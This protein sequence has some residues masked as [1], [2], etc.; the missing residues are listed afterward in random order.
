MVHYIDAISVSI[1]VD[2][3]VSRGVN[4]GYFKK[5]RFRFFGVPLPLDFRDFCRGFGLLSN[6]FLVAGIE[7]HFADFDGLLC[8]RPFEG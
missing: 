6:D 5:M 4:G 8:V 2:I 3:T 1:L 7:F